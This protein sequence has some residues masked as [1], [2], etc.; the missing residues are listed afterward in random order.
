S[1]VLMPVRLCVLLSFSVLLSGCA[2]FY[3]MVYGTVSEPGDRL[4]FADFISEM[5]QDTVVVL[6]RTQCYGMCPAYEVAVYGDGTV[7]YNGVAHVA[8]FGVVQDTLAKPVVDSLLAAFEA[9]DYFAFPD[10]LGYAHYEEC[11]VLVT[12]LPTVTTAL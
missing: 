2:M 9:A 10:S 1:L 6:E 7:V 8:R 11:A 3:G 5:P 12:D 4:G